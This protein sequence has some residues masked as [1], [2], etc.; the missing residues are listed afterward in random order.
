MTN[1]EW[2]LLP[3]KLPEERAVVWSGVSIR[4]A[5]TGLQLAGSRGTLAGIARWGDHA[6]GLES[7]REVA[8]LGLWHR[9]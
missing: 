9:V 1:E 2:A 3:S 4:D 5:K 7:R 8:G 6:G